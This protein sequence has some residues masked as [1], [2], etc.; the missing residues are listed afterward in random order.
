MQVAAHE[1]SSFYT[2]DCFGLERC[3]FESNVPIDRFAG[4]YGV[5]SKALNKIA[6][7]FTADD[8]D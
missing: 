3:L 6:Q 5:L 8:R 2:I 1:R 4:S 7:R